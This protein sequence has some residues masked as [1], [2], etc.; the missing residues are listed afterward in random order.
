MPDKLKT[1]PL[2]VPIFFEKF[3]HLF[4]SRTIGINFFGFTQLTNISISLKLEC[5]L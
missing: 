5:K 1:Y 2:Y 4:P 3:Y